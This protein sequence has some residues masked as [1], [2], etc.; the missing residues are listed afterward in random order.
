MANST[1]FCLLF[2]YS[3][4]VYFCVEFN[5]ISDN[6]EF[7]AGNDG[8]TESLFQCASSCDQTFIFIFIFSSGGW[9]KIKL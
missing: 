1:F 5:S 9:G 2:R 3:R 7:R 4:I 6:T 8:F